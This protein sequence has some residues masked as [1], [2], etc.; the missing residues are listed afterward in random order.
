[1]PEFWRGY[2]IKGCVY[3]SA[4]RESYSGTVPREP[5]VNIALV[6]GSCPYSRPG[7][8]VRSMGSVSLISNRHISKFHLDLELERESY[9]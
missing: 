8:A 7:F 5:S 1:M 3:I 2:L 4:R 6:I 9:L